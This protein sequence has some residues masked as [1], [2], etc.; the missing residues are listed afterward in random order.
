MQGRRDLVE[1]LARQPYPPAMGHVSELA[2]TFSTSAALVG[3][4]MCSEAQLNFCG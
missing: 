4:A 2:R 3:A 1:T